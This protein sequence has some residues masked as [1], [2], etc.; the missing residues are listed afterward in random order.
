VHPG[1]H[2][3]VALGGLGL[4][5]GGAYVV[6]R[7]IKKEF[8]RELDL[9]GAAVPAITRIG[10]VGWIALG[11]CYAVPGV[12]LVIA[13]L[14]YDP[15][16]PVGLDAGL[17]TLA[18]QPFGAPLLVLLGVGVAAFGIFCFVDARHRKA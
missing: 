5:A 7:G 10:Q 15:K 1:G 8:L 12:L 4:V 14:R 9:R 13:G 18:D 2:Y 3:L 17:K 6:Y 11:F 16:A